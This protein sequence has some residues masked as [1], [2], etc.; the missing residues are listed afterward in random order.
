[1]SSLSRRSR[2]MAQAI[3]LPL[4]RSKTESRSRSRAL[5]AISLARLRCIRVRHPC[6]LPDGNR[7]F[8][9]RGLASGVGGRG[10]P[11]AKVVPGSRWTPRRLVHRT[12]RGP[13][14]CI[15]TRRPGDRAAQNGEIGL[16]R[17]HRRARRHPVLG[18]CPAGLGK[19]DL[20]SGRHGRHI[21][22]AGEDCRRL[23]DVNRLRRCRS[24]CVPF[25]YPYFSRRLCPLVAGTIRAARCPSPEA[26]AARFRRGPGR[27]APNPGRSCRS[28]TARWNGRTRPGRRRPV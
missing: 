26:R 13:K 6:N 2:S 24:R 15:G 18:G 21:D 7:S 20:R 23:G 28:R 5:S 19:P 10:S 27:A 14:F 1:M 16:V 11:T 22:L 17:E 9:I 3:R 25:V 12:A 8:N 4:P